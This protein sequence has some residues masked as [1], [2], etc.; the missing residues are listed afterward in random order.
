MKI[1][2]FSLWGDDK[3]YCQGA[4]DNVYYAKKYYP[5]WTCRFY[6][7]VDCPALPILRLMDCQVVTMQRLN[8]INRNQD[9][10]TWTWDKNNIGMLWRFLVLDD[11][12][13]DKVVFR[14]ADGRVGP[15]DADAVREW[16]ESG[17]IAHRMH[18]CK[19]HWNA[20]I[21]GGMWGMKNVLPFRIQDA[22]ND[23]IESY[24]HIRK[25]PWIFVDLWFIMDMIWPL[26]SYSCLGHG[27][28]HTNS[29]KVDGSMVGAVTH[30][31]W[32]G[33]KYV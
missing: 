23:Y 7:A 21:M 26:I 30:E 27:F 19:E 13:V 12:S 29:F 28:G 17:K 24:T 16:E 2:S 20:Q 22:I 8:G 9:A 15:R 33:Q 32:R 5:D 1:I 25:E 11:F 10:L 18:E 6:V 3:L 14:D 31:E 4:I